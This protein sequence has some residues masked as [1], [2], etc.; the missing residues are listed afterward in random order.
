[1]N[2]AL[3][4]LPK[5]DAESMANSK[6]YKGGFDPTMNRREAALILGKFV[7]HFQVKQHHNQLIPSTE[8]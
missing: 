8:H 2:E 7:Q 6:Y 5:F 1:M 4:N 3:K